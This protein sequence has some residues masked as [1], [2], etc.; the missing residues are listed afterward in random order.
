[1]CGVYRWVYFQSF[2]LYSDFPSD[3]PSYSNFSCG[4]P[5]DCLSY[6][7]FPMI[8]DDSMTPEDLECQYHARV[9]RL[10]A[11]DVAL[12]SIREERIGLQ[13][14]LV[15]LDRALEAKVE[16][17]AA[18]NSAV[19][20]EFIRTVARLGLETPGVE[21]FYLELLTG[22]PQEGVG[23]APF[24]CSIQSAW[25]PSGISYHARILTTDLGVKRRVRAAFQEAAAG[26]LPLG[27]QSIRDHYAT[28]WLI[29]GG[30]AIRYTPP[31]L[32]VPV[33]PVVPAVPAPPAPV[34]AAG[35]GGGD[36]EDEEDEDEEDEEDEED[37]E[38]DEEDEGALLE[39]LN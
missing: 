33:A 7:N 34:A 36:E 25:A 28:A 11:L 31:A 12:Q 15:S 29:R 32:V 18:E 9:L 30:G 3:F 16:P 24:L 1:M 26:P 39:E 23:M 14:Q 8:S 27:V 5:S 20:D 35:G 4:R 13:S 22:L 6:S 38:E 19:L 17:M 2:R 10:H 37:D 21:R